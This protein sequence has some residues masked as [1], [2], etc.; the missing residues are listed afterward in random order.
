[1]IADR[2]LFDPLL[3]D[4]VFL[5][6]MNAS[7]VRGMWRALARAPDVRRV[8]RALGSDPG[9]IRDLCEFVEE[10]LRT[11]Y[12]RAYRHPQDVAICAALVVLEQSPLSPVRNLFARLRRP[13]ERSLAWVQRMAEHCEERFVPSDRMV[14]SVPYHSRLSGVG[15]SGQNPSLTWVSAT[16][17]QREHLHVGV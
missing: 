7:D 6:G 4:A 1:M 15:V 3:S 14:L 13:K 16:Q 10:L 11:Q 2:A 5:E 12:D 9:R 8:S 17:D